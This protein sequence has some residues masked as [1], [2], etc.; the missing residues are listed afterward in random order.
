MK[1]TLSITALLATL[2]LPALADTTLYG[3]FRG[4]LNMG[5]LNSADNNDVDFVNNASRLGVKGSIGNG[6]LKGIY[7]LQTLVNFDSNDED[8]LSKRFYFAGLKGK[9]GKVI[10]GRLSTPYKMSAIKEDAFRD[11]SAGAANKGPNYGYSSL[12][13]SFTDSTI[14][15]YSPKF[16]GGVQAH[17]SITID[18]SATDDHDVGIGVE[19]ANKDFKVGISHLDLGDTPV[20]ANH[21][22][23]EK[24]TRFYGSKKFKAFAVNLS[25]E[26]VDF[27]SGKDATF[28]HIN[29]TYKA[30]K[31]TKL[32]LAYGN[33]DGD[34]KGARNAAGEG[35]SAGVFYNVLKNTQ[36][37]AIYS[38][39]DYEVGKDRDGFALGIVQKF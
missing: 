35:V 33:V 28:T 19:Y 26:K 34:G 32:A 38:N 4:S 15:Y 9:F 36:L 6:N 5:D 14:A 24:A 21:G 3:S 39:V 7:H 25:Y 23:A 16:A 11:T 18:D 27:N 22:G 2:S 1:K 12:T 20:V 30:N 13:S 10:Y 17:A 37:S 31:K 29:S 8:A